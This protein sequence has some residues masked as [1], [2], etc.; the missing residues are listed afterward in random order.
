LTDSAFWA[1]RQK[2]YKGDKAIR[3]L[4]DRY[5]MSADDRRSLV[6]ASQE[7]Q[8]KA[9]RMAIEAH[10]KAWPRCAGT[11]LWQLNDVWPGASWSIVEYGGRRKPAFHAVKTA[12]AVDPIN[13]PQ[14]MDK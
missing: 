8:A 7:L 11:L 3:A 5:G 14:A 4:A 6:N 12:Y 9:Y 2:S 13:P 10:L 1:G